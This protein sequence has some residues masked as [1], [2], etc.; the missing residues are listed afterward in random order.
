MK[1]SVREIIQKK[2]LG[3]FASIN[4]NNSI[5]EALRVLEYTKVSALLVLDNDQVK[6]VFSEKDFARSVLQKK[7]HLTDPV[8]TVMTSEVLYVEP[9]FTLQEC[10]ELMTKA[11]IRHLP[12]IENS[13]PIAMLSMRHIME[14]LVEEKENQIRDLTQY[15]TGTYKQPESLQ[16]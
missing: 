12:V 4:P 13:K 16:A 14:L 6:G 3:F 1:R 9:N 7:V 15:I 5:Y 10:L 11:H 8:S 2:S